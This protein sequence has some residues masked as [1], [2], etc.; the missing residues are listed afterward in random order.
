MQIEDFA[1]PR[2]TAKQNVS[3]NVPPAKEEFAAIAPTTP[4]EH[5]HIL[6]R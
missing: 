4:K 2:G 5:E 3:I 6:S 1:R